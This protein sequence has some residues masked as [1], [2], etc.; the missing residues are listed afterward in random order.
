MT[1]NVYEISN[2]V[3]SQTDEERKMKK[4]KMLTIGILTAVFLV[5]P[6]P[7]KAFLPALP[8]MA[9]GGAAVM[10]MVESVPSVATTL[11]SGGA[12]LYAGREAMKRG[13]QQAASYGMRA[14]IKPSLIKHLVRNAGL[15][16]Q[17]IRDIRHARVVFSPSKVPSGGKQLLYYISL[18]HGGKRYYKIGI[19]TKSLKQR[20]RREYHSAKISPVLMLE[21]PVK[22]ALAIE[23]AIKSAFYTQRVNN[24][25]ILPYDGGYTEVYERD[26]LEIDGMVLSALR[27]MK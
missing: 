14:Y 22:S 1:H 15:R 19:T 17:M 4:I 24:R 13:V 6:V 5:A 21:M 11:S 27:I 3:I 9:E 23:G 18:E 10:A 16:K 7:S 25:A 12:M 8:V 20:Y 2:N 26:I